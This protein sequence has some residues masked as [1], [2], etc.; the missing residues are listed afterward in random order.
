[1]C[2]PS[3]QV[4]KTISDER[5]LHAAHIHALAHL[6][7]RTVIVVQHSNPVTLTRYRPGWDSDQLTRQQMLELHADTI[8]PPLL[9]HLDA[10]STHFSAILPD[11]P[12]ARTSK[13]KLTHAI[14]GSRASQ[15]VL[16]E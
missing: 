12:R 2:S 1:M 3:L 4:E 11:V 7:Q 15:I 6:Q 9:I 13:R 16:E 5:F 10:N 14:G 8:H